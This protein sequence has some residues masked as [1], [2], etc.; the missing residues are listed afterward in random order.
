MSVFEAAKC[1]E[2]GVMREKARGTRQH[3]LENTENKMKRI[4]N[5]WEARVSKR[6]T[7]ARTTLRRMLQAL[8]LGWRGLC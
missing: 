4:E 5:K 8:W 6:G 7:A 3:K 1:L 2:A